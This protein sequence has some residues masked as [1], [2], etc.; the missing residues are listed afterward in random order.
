MQTI[1]FIICYVK[2]KTIARITTKMNTNEKS[3]LI[4]FI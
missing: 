1:V 3:K 2:F 4:S